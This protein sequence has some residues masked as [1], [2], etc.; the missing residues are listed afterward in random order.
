MPRRS[1]LRN[2][3]VEEMVH[4]AVRQHFQAGEGESTAFAGGTT[5]ATAPHV[6]PGYRPE[7][8]DQAEAFGPGQ[9][10]GFEG[11]SQNPLE[12]EGRRRISQQFGQ[13]PLGGYVR[14]AATG[15]G[16][17]NDHAILAERGLAGLTAVGIGVPA[18]MAAVQQLSTPQDQ[19]TIPF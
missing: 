12:E 3:A 9:I 16:L 6:Q 5:G 18:F 2:P 14:D 13:A 15:M 10:S 11:Y 8:G 19:N 17:S 4:P 7:V 1:S